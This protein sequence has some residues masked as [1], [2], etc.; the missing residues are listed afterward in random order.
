V[1]G[2]GAVAAYAGGMAG[3]AFGSG[4]HYGSA[5]GNKLW[6]DFT[7]L[8]T[9][10]AAEG[11]QYLTHMAYS[12]GRGLSGTALLNDAWAH[13]DITLN[14]ANLGSIM[15]AAGFIAGVNSDGYSPI[16]RASFNTAARALSA[17]G[18]DLSFSGQGM[19][20]TL[21]SSGYDLVDISMGIGKGLVL[22]KK[23]EEFAA[24][25]TK[26]ANNA[27]KTLY[28]HGDF[29]G[30]ETVWRLALGKDSLD[31]AA[32]N[33]KAQTTSDLSGNR[34]LRLPENGDGTEVMLDLAVSLQHESW[35]NGLDDGIAGQTVETY[36]AALAHT[37]MAVTLAQ[38]DYGVAMTS[39]VGCDANYKMDIAN[40]LGSD[41]AAYVANTYES[42]GDFWKLM[43]N[44]DLVDD[45]DGWLRDQNGNYV[46]DS[47][48][49]T[50]GAK[51]KE[52]GL[53]NIL[54]GGTAGADYN[55][56]SDTQIDMVQ[57]LMENSG[58]VHTG[59]VDK[60]A[61]MWN[62]TTGSTITANSISSG[63]G[64]SVATPVF[65]N[66]MDRATDIVLFSDNFN[67]VD[68]TMTA[69]PDLAESRF[70]SY[71]KAKAGFY[72]G[73]H[74]LW[75]DTKGLSLSQ[76]FQ[77]SIAYNGNQHRGGDIAGPSGTKILAGYGGKVVRNTEDYEL[78]TSGN[79]LVVEYGFDF[80]NSFYST[81]IQAQY[82]HLTE[83]SMHTVGQ[84]IIADTI[85]GS[86][87]NTGSV[88]PKRTSVNPLA[89]T[90]LHYQLMGNM[91]G[92]GATHVAWSMLD[93][94]RN[95]FLSQIGAPSTDNYVYNQGT[96]IKNNYT[97]SVG[98]PAVDYYNYF[99]NPNEW[100]KRMGL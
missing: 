97:G 3:A 55:Q 7:N 69:I 91:P 76:I 26:T 25:Q 30:E 85:I 65:M 23:L 64:D 51:G 41:F 84:T 62:G 14:V 45:G 40:Y 34:I 21:G 33:G 13:H 27:M 32:G 42:S 12:A 75:K 15:D 82:M 1:L 29:A 73:E 61:R 81:G 87:G 70:A 22:N 77:E 98:S 10:A 47:D 58:M 35:R 39:L 78:S 86:M 94:R 28:S 31:W 53:L 18:F 50:I 89:G 57:R 68:R 60:K 54:Y 66:G 19:T 6:S 9:M 4:V 36:M 88:S 90:H 52:T 24:T 80:E 67:Q 48:G 99:Y 93:S 46:K 2:E 56:Y 96:V 63:F 44:G 38:G 16:E 79:T 20:G 17:F 71:L 37:R 59:Q 49:N 83:Q 95:T 74:T 43:A 11:A 92:Y 5:Y 100:L 72:A 8:G